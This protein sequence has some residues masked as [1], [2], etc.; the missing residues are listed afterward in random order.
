MSVAHFKRR[1]R[2]ALILVRELADR[3]FSRAAGAPLV[4][5]N[6]VRLLK[7]AA[8]NYPAW[9]EAIAAAK[10]SIHFESYIIHEDHVGWTFADAL[11]A[12]AR[13]GVQVRVL[14]DWLGGFGKTSRSFWNH[15]RAGGV[16]V[17]CY[18]SPQWDSPFG[19]LSRNKDMTISADPT[20]IS[21]TRT[22][23]TP[24]ERVSRPASQRTRGAT[25]QLTSS[26]RTAPTTGDPA[27]PPNRPPSASRT[28]PTT[29]PSD[30]W[31]IAAPWMNRRPTIMGRAVVTSAARTALIGA[32]RRSRPRGRQ[33][34]RP[35]VD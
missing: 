28:I 20:P 27:R 10:R 26:M 11:T 32:P 21:T 15:L 34:L 5:G 29:A 33:S 24:G 30:H 9:L 6:R 31:M 3:V 4:D 16:E 25:N 17:R 23:H 12:R 19:W 2:D 22:R 8:E 7:D 13:E 1:E 18:N 14:Y 35:A